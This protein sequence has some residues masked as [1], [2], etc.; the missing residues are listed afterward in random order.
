[1][2]TFQILKFWK[3]TGRRL[4]SQQTERKSAGFS[5]MRGCIATT[6]I[7]KCLLFFFLLLKAHSRDRI[8]VRVYY[9][10]TRH[11]PIMRSLN[12]W[13]SRRLRSLS[14]SEVLRSNWSV[15]FSSYHGL[16]VTKSSRPIRLFDPL[17]DWIVFVVDIFLYYSLLYKLL[18]MLFNVKP[19]KSK[20][21]VIR[22]ECFYF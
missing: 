8:G 21:S 1:M 6:R 7:C 20:T 13:A 16:Y 19:L 11:L 4:F 18:K 3:D 17:A 14:G 12:E 22:R 5:L 2:R 9:Y 15:L 10:R